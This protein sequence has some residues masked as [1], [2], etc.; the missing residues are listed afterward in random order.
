MLGTKTI[1]NI[2]VSQYVNPK[3]NYWKRVFSLFYVENTEADANQPVWRNRITL[4]KRYILSVFE[5]VTY[6]KCKNGCK[7]FYIRTQKD[8]TRNVNNECFIVLKQP[9]GN[10]RKNSC[11]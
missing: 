4:P 5:L 2:E 8:F 3:E 1:N 10:K 11:I 6:K 7:A 9:Q